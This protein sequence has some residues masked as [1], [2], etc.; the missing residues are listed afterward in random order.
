MAL[1]NISIAFAKIEV[2]QSNQKI[3]KLFNFSILSEIKFFQ[4]QELT[5]SL[6]AE[7]KSEYIEEWILKKMEPSLIEIFSPEDLKNFTSRHKLTLLYLGEPPGLFKKISDDHVDVFFIYSKNEDLLRL[8]PQKILLFKSHKPTPITFE[9]ELNESLSDFLED[10]RYDDII[11]MTFKTKKRVFTAEENILYLFLNNDE[12]EEEAEIYENFTKFSLKYHDKFL[13]VLYNG[14]QEPVMEYFLTDLGVR[15]QSM[16]CIR[17]SKFNEN[18]AESHPD[19]YFYPSTSFSLENLERFF[20]DIQE[21]K[22]KPKEAA[23]PKENPEI[24]QDDDSKVKY[25]RKSA[26]EQVVYDPEKDVVVL[27]FEPSDE[28]CQKVILLLKNYLN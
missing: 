7:L 4:N 17:F 9:G 25:I 24:K 11:V 28:L 5:G 18:D 8:F 26:F 6:S 1:K 15:K 22:I 27:F 2:K 12:P 21:K 16:P 20:E 10:N 23:Q 13:A 3:G 14:Y 19:I